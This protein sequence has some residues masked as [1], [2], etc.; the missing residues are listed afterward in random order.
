M[1]SNYLK[2]ALRNFWRNKLYTSLNVGGLAIGLAA[3]LLMVLYVDHEFSYDQFHPKA[4][5]IVR[6]TSVMKTPES[7][8]AIASDPI[9]LAP[10]LKRDYPEVE[11]AVRFLMT[12]GTVKT[13]DKLVNQADVYYA[14]NDVFSVFAYPFLAGN[15]AT[16][17]V[18]PNSAVVTEKFAHKYFGKTDILGKSIEINKTTYQITGVMA[19]LPSNTDLPISALLSKKQSESTDWLGDDFPAYTYILFRNEPNLPD[20]S[21]KLAKL[22]KKYLAPALKKAGAENYSINFDLEPLTDAHYSQGKLEDTPKGNRQFSYLFAFL[23]VFVLVIALLNYINLLTAK[24]TERAKEVGIRKATGAQYG[25]LVRQFLLE[26]LL[27]SGL[28]IGIA[29]GLLQLTIPLFNDQL[30][31]QMQ[32]GWAEAVSVV[33]CTWLIVTLL[34]GLYPA[35][36]LSGY[37][38]VEV[39]KGQ[40]TSHGQGLWLRKTIIVFQFVLAVSMIAGVLV[41]H[42]QMHYLQHYDVGYTR[43]QILSLYLPD[44]STARAAAPAFANSLKQHS[45]VDGITLGFGLANGPMAMSSTTIRTNGKKREVMSNYLFIDD[46]FVPLLNI[47]LKAG[48]NLSSQYKTDLNGGFLVNEAFVK[49]AGW[50]QGEGQAISGFGHKGTVVGVL[51][52]FNYRSLHNPVEPLVLIYCTVPAINVMARVRPSALPIIQTIWQQHYPN[53]PFEY[54]FLDTSFDSEYRKDRLMMMI[55][56]CFAGLT[57]LVSCLG[58]FGLIAFTTERRTK[59]IGVRKVLGASVANIVTLLTN[60]FLKLIGIAILIASPLAWWAADRW[61]QAFAYKTDL[62]WWVFALAGVLSIAIALLTISFQSIK[63][64]LMNPVNSL[65]TE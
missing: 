64:A 4:R 63:A 55:F 29:L 9:P 12:G 16:A 51:K 39:L 48:R 35:F 58:L 3:C 45:E 21:K 2:I 20:F 62:S 42:R 50:K 32:F 52:N 28:S 56:N 25:Q 59:E 8:L 22:S 27:L 38:P 5:R 60:D 18:N 14:D 6:V 26:S 53:Y 34:G 57:I 37:R 40:L 30:A 24:A 44:D 11:T 10:T 54:S 43:E 41:I 31:I 13:N 49:M 17:L 1:L 7:S 36:V 33:V 46:K 65:K 19:N 15:P 61:L 47:G 23:A